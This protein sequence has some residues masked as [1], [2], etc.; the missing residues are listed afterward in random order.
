MTAPS[1]EVPITR[2]DFAVR[3]AALPT[4]PRRL[5]CPDRDTTVSAYGGSLR[6][7]DVHTA[8]MIEVTATVWC[9][10]SKD[11]QGVY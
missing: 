9:A 10:Q 8:K 11:Y 3:A 4:T 6:R 7:Y 2:I 5:W 1:T